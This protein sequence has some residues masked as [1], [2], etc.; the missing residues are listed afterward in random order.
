MR[1]KLHEIMGIPAEY[2]HE[3]G[4]PEYTPL[5]DEFNSRTFSAAP[6]PAEEEESAVKRIL[7]AMMLLG[8]SGLTLTGVLFSRG[9]SGGE[10]AA[11]PLPTPSVPAVVETVTASPSPFVTAA[12]G[13][14]PLPTEQPAAATV[15]APTETPYFTPDPND[16]TFEE[17]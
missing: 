17:D 3:D 10:A 16:M 4:A 12:P 2:S 8:V 1:K 9:A 14:T 11:S 13:N 15:P 7:K 5:P 6:E